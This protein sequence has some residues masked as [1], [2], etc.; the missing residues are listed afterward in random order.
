MKRFVWA[1]VLV[2][3]ILELSASIAQSNPPKVVAEFGGASL[4][5]IHAAEPEFQRKKLDL[6]KYIISVVEQD[7]S[8]IVILRSSDSVQGSFGSTGKYPG[9][10]VEIGKKDLKVARSNYVR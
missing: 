9:Y 3:S 8:V 2:I 6:D 7:D 4:K 10:E 1:I 5:W